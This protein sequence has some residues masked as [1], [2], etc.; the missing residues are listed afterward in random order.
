MSSAAAKKPRASV[1][2]SRLPNAPRRP[3][4]LVIGASRGL[5]R[6][7]AFT[8]V[9]RGGY[10]VG[11]AAKSTSSAPNDDSKLPGTVYS[12]C[13]EINEAMG[14]ASHAQVALPIPCNVL[15]LPDI[16]RAVQSVVRE[17]GGIDLVVYNAGAIW[18]DAVSATPTKRYEL[19]HGVNTRGCYEAVQA[20]LPIF[21]KQNSGV[22]HIRRCGEHRALCVTLMLVVCV[23]WMV[24]CVAIC[25]DITATVQSISEW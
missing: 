12:V 24:R 4:A 6:Q 1:G 21:T 22:M 2:S 8:L 14:G 23:V 16:Q 5:G 17:F 20:V 13:R 19:M 3:V 10:S 25:V 11:V 9:T 7:I 15:H 18:W